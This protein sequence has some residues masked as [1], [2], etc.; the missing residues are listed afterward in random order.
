MTM[1][2]VAGFVLAAA[3]AVAARTARSL[4]TTGA[5]AATLVGALAVAAGWSWGVLLIA[6]FV[7]S[8]ALSHLGRVAKNVRTRSVV[9][10]TGARDA[11]QVLANGGVFALA[12]LVAIVHHDA[13]WM[14]AGAGALAASAAD[15]WGTEIGTLYGGTPRSI[16][17]LRPVP[18][19]TSGGVSVIGS[20]ATIAGACFMA[21]LA[22]ALKWGT[23]AASVALAGGI[24]GALADSLIGA[25]VQ[26]RRRCDPCGVETERIT[27][28]CGA[29]THHTRGVRWLDNDA[30]NLVA[31]IVGATLAGCL[32]A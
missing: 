15:T 1:R 20:V 26:A 4:T 24:A 30:V 2:I 14:A 32:A 9:E 11:I 29:T 17:T 5:I 18:P 23:R 22:I 25:T 10:K 13:T 28:D 21:V 27:H 7:S 31:T 8:S 12:A 3:I 16:V 19:G 6:Y